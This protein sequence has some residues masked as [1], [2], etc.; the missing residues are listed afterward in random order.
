M[1]I[2]SSNIALE[3]S[4]SL[5]QR[6]EKSER[7]TVSV[8]NIDPG[9]KQSHKPKC[10]KKPKCD[11]VSISEKALKHMEKDL[12]RTIA[13][14]NE[15]IIGAMAHNGKGLNK[16]LRH[17]EKDLDKALRH[18]NNKLNKAMEHNGRGIEKA[19][20]HLEK[21]LEKAAEHLNKNLDSEKTGEVKIGRHEATRAGLAKRLIHGLTGKKVKIKDLKE[22]LKNH[23]DQKD[24]DKKVKSEAHEPEMKA[25]NITYDSHEA[26]YEKEQMS[27]N[28]GGVV[29][30]ADGREITFSLDLMM[31]REFMSE[32]TVNLAAAGVGAGNIVIDFEGPASDLSDSEFTVIPDSEEDNES[33][34][35][36]SV[37]GGRLT[38]DLNNDGQIN[39]DNEIIGA[40]TGNGFAELAV[41]DEDG[42]GWIDE[43]DSVYQQLSVYSKDAEGNEAVSGLKE[44]NVGAIN[45]G[46]VDT[47]FALKDSE[48]QQVGQIEKSGVYLNEDGTAGI[49]QQ[50]SVKV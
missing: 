35:F 14:L 46:S 33:T 32:T 43:N 42:N 9:E 24:D 1:I 45:L 7:L 13:R 11:R 25:W 4:H 40:S 2:D 23:E 3:S 30:T 12:D 21:D 6:Y 15:Q 17:L 10:D 37:G 20:K 5:A 28:A 47:R 27:F 8:K 26:Y 50:V 18:M 36:L 39:G 16:A 38:L 44:S 19:L 31:S 22:L 34:T 49:V 29:R 41:H 48:N